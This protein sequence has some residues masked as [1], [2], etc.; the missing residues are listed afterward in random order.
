MKRIALFMVVCCLVTW[1]TPGV[2]QMNT[3]YGQA[4][5]SPTRTKGRTPFQRPRDRSFQNQQGT[6]FFGG[7]ENG[8]PILPMPGGGGGGEGGDLYQIH[9]L[10]YVRVP[11]TYRVA[12]STRVSEA[13]GAAGGADK[14]G[15]I[16]KVELRQ[17]GKRV[18]RVDLFQYLRRGDLN[19]NP[20]VQDNDVVYVPL[21]D[22]SVRID[23]PV[24]SPGLYELTNA[25]GS[26][27]DI[28]QIAGGYSSGVSQSGNVVIVRY[29]ADE[30][31]QLVEVRNDIGELTHTPVRDGD[32]IVI[33][34]LLTKGKKFDYNLPELPSDNVFYPSFDD[35]VYVIGAVS[36]P[37]PYPFNAHFGMREYMLMAGPTK[38]ATHTKPQIMTAS[39]RVVKSTT[40]YELSPG[41]TIVV[42]ER[43]V[44][45]SKGLTLYN[46]LANTIITGFTL[47]ELFRR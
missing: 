13:I 22:A 7:Q 8:E 10:G 20:F 44:T 39:G 19:A 14:L 43:K 31:K 27:W 26:V 30:K 41:D 38:D 1:S 9:V 34:H 29:G 23:G 16:R 28:I 11:G 42:P 18:R 25:G 3:G 17:G 46:T 32:T 5:G 40:G 36:Q 2:A 24:K 4:L 33:P 37:G 47:R 15:S 6:D 45:F 12:P 35:N 21:V